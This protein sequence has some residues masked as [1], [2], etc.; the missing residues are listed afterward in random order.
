MD[1]VAPCCRA[2]QLSGIC[3][4]LVPSEAALIFSCKMP[5]KRIS[6]GGGRFDSDGGSDA[7]NGGGKSKVTGNQ[8]PKPKN[9]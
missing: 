8:T 5:Q 9:H 6:W 7:T 1:P 4:A 2:S 3:C